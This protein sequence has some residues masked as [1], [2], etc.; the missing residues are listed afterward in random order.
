MLVRRGTG[1]VSDRTEMT[2]ITSV[3]AGQHGA[4][5]PIRASMLDLSLS[6]PG[7]MTRERSCVFRVADLDLDVG[8]ACLSKL[9]YG[10]SG[11][12]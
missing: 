8:L 7:V 2:A 1:M 4:T 3:L 11:R 12:C 10:H 9:G 6:C 5:A